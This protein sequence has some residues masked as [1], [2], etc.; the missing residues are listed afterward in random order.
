M[1]KNIYMV[2]LVFLLLLSIGFSAPQTQSF[3]NEL[4]IETLQYEYHPYNTTYYL[5]G[6]IH[7]GI[8]GVRLNPL[9]VTC[10]YHLYAEYDNWQHVNTGVLAPFGAG[11]FADI[12]ASEFLNTGEYAIMM[13]CESLD[14]TVNPSKLFGGFVRYFFTV[15]EPETETTS[16][17]LLVISLIIMILVMIAGLVFKQNILGI[18]GSLGLLIVGIMFIPTSYVIG[19]VVLVT[20]LLLSLVFVFRS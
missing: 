1:N 20:G 5:H 19:I 4:I 12:N 6:H 18:V 16:L 3:D 17:S 13:W 14:T 9:D 2:G 7:S 15:S 11:M 10:N 8:T